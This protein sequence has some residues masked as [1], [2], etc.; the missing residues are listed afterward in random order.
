M[1]DWRAQGREAVALAL[2]VALVVP[3]VVGWC[4]LFVGLWFL[5][6]R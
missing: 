1:T 6:A 5:V 3:L 4:V 2:D